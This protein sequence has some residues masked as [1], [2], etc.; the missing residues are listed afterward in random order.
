MSQYVNSV[1]YVVKADDTPHQVV[2]DGLKRLRKVNAPVV[3]VVLNQVSP[4]KKG[5][6]GYYSSDYYHYYGYENK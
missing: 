5:K 3:G 6:Y 1:A 4:P 2:N